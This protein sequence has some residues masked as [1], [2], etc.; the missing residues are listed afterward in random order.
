MV[1]LPFSQR[2]ATTSKPLK[3]NQILDALT[4]GDKIR[5]RRLTLGLFQREVAKNFKVSEDT[6]VNWESNKATPAVRHYPQIIEFLQDFPFDIDTATI[7]GKIRMYR[8]LRGLSRKQLAY[9]L[10]VDK[11][12]IFHYENNVHIPLKQNLRRLK[13][14]FEVVEQYISSCV[15][16]ST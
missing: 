9:N 15:S 4:L 3:N 11:S 2:R 7:G 12:T 10:K 6:I 16:H 8:Y 14:I 1:A 13:V 5:N